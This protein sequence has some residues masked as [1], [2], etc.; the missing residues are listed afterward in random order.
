MVTNADSIL[1]KMF[2][3]C[4]NNIK[5]F[6]KNKEYENICLKYELIGKDVEHVLN[7]YTYIFIPYITWPNTESREFAYKNGMIAHMIFVHIIPNFCGIFCLL[8]FG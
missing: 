1:E 8:Y 2:S 3:E 5:D 4:Q 6:C 7:F